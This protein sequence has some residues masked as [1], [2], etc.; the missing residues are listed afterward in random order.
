MKKYYLSQDG[1]LNISI[2]SVSITCAHYLPYNA[3]PCHLY[4]MGASHQ[5]V[6]VPWLG[7]MKM[8][9]WPR[10]WTFTP[11]SSG[12]GMEQTHPLSLQ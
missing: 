11:S 3:S 2:L 12:R 5:G 8:K 9:Q 6:R 10:T 4:R 1:L 7:V